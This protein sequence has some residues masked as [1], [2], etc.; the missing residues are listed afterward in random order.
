ML[1]CMK[2]PQFLQ[3]H[4]SGQDVNCNLFGLVRYLAMSYNIF[5]YGKIRFV[6]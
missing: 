1:N 6:F 4:L 2:T 5:L 3:L